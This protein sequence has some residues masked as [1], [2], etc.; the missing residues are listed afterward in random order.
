M[1][2]KES[3]RVIDVGRVSDLE[4]EDIAIVKIAL[5]RDNP[6]VAGDAGQIRWHCQSQAGKGALQHWKRHTLNP[7]VVGVVV[8]PEHDGEVVETGRPSHL[9]GFSQIVHGVF[10][11][12]VDLAPGWGVVEYPRFCVNMAG[13]EQE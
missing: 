6:V 8:L 2:G 3:A 13:V 5:G 9:D 11:V 12:I 1:A 7:L 10:R 4:E